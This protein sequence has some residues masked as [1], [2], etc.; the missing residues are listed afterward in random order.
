LGSPLHAPAPLHV[1]GPLHS[2][3]G[4]IPLAIGW[5]SPSAAPV[6][7][8]RHDWQVP[9]HA[10]SQQTP[11]CTGQKPLAHWFAAEHVA[12]FAASWQAPP[13]H[14]LCPAHSLSG[15]L[16]PV[17][18]AQVPSTPPVFAATQ[19]SQAPAHAWSQH[20]SSCP[21]QKPLAH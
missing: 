17:S 5:Q 20:T 8:M 6:F 2:L 1:L 3:L 16:P 12:P 19:P 18:G 7:V 15:S 14:V 11:S 10:S 13:E 4:S 9:P 21:G